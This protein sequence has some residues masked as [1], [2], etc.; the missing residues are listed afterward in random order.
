MKARAANY[1]AVLWRLLKG[2]TRWELWAV[3]R[4]E[5]QPK[6]KGNGYRVSFAHG[7]HKAQKTTWGYAM[8]DKVFNDFEREKMAEIE[9]LKRELREA[10]VTISTLRYALGIVRDAAA[11]QETGWHVIGD[12]G[13]W[14]EFGTALEAEAHAEACAKEGTASTVVRVTKQFPAEMVENWCAYNGLTPGVDFP[15][16][17]NQPRAA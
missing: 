3:G 1:T 16:T 2:L 11:A 14:N 6:G 10:N 15:G 7:N 8:S 9:H 17:P 4:G 5:L 12:D 13:E